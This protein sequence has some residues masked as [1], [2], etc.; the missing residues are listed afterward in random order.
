MPSYND[1]RYQTRQLM[2]VADAA[3]FAV[4]GTAAADSILFRFRV[5]KS[6]TIDGASIIALTGGIC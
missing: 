4:A 1:N 6:I 5:P 2:P 3:G